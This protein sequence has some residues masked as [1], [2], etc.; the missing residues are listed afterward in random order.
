MSIVRDIPFTLNALEDTILITCSALMSTAGSTA[1]KGMLSVQ[2]TADALVATAETTAF[3]RIIDRTAFP[4]GTRY[5]VA[6]PAAYL[7]STR[8]TTD[9]DAKVTIGVKLQHGDSSGGG[10]MADYSTGNQPDDR[11]FFSTARSTAH[12]SW[13]ATLSTGEFYGVS[14]PAYYDLRGAKQY[15]RV[16]VPV[17]KNSQ[18]TESTGF[19]QSRV[20]A[21]LTFL[22]G[23]NLPQADDV[24]SAFSTSTST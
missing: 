7:H 6:A 24:T 12:A 9:A 4:I 8:G 23:A 19:E 5:Q 1:A 14:N 2:T 20:G 21:T 15:L 22:G 16:A 18:T 17:S 11:Q 3:G 10:D 13:D